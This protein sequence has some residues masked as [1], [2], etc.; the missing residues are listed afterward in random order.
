MRVFV[1]VCV[2]IYMCVCVCVY[3]YV[4]IIKN[5]YIIRSSHPLCV[6]NT[7]LDFVYFTLI[8]FNCIF[9]ILSI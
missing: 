9:Y 8:C 6:Y 2:C 1:F 7:F 5:V 4:R 3:M